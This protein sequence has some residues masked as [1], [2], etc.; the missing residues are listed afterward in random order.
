MVIYFTPARLFTGG[1]LTRIAPD[2]VVAQTEAGVL[3]EGG[4]T[5]V[6]DGDEFYVTTADALF[7]HLQKY[8]LF[9]SSTVVGTAVSRYKSFRHVTPSTTDTTPPGDAAVAVQSW[10]DTS[11]TLAHTPPA[12]ADYDHTT[13]FAVLVPGD[14]VTAP[15][16]ASG[17]G[18]S[19]T[20]TGLQSG[21]SYFLV[22]IAYDASGN[23]SLIGASS[24]GAG[25]TWPTDSPAL[26]LLVKCFVNQEAT[27]RKVYALDPTLVDANGAGTTNFELRPNTRGRTHRIRLECD[28]PVMIRLR[29]LGGVF[30]VRDAEVGGLKGVA[31]N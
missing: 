3:V 24:V 6:L 5:P 1:T 16:T 26:P 8:R 25:Q 23:P 12:D 29:S 11:V 31:G 13:I 17:T 19:I 15:V 4:L 22:A 14:G 18:T 28:A 2:S 9:I 27:P 20:V 10:T 7:T 21:R 30:Q